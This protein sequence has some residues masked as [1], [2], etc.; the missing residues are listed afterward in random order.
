ME[1]RGEGLEKE[2]ELELTP[3]RGQGSW[4]KLYDNYYQYANTSFSSAVNTADGAFRY[5]KPAARGELKVY[6]ER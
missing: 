5:P 4:A 3:V 1:L 6:L 2:Q